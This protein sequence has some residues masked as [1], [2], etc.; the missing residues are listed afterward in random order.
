[1]TKRAKLSEAQRKALV[2]ARDRGNATAHLSG[3]ADWGGWGSTRRAL[4]QRGYLDIACQITE[5][6][7]KAVSFGEQGD[8]K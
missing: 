1:M 8:E 5:A 4:Q 3:M 7:R 2:S 6:G